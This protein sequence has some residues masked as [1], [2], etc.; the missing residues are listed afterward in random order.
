MGLLAVEVWLGLSCYWCSHI[1]LMMFTWIQLCIL[2][3]KWVCAVSESWTMPMHST[4]YSVVEKVALVMESFQR[5]CIEYGFS[6]F[7]LKNYNIKVSSNSSCVL[8]WTVSR[9]PTITCGPWWNVRVLIHALTCLDVLHVYDET[10]RTSGNKWP[11]AGDN[12][13]HW[14]WTSSTEIQSN[15]MNYSMCKSQTAVSFTTTAVSQNIAR[16]CTVKTCYIISLTCAL[17][18]HSHAHVYMCVCSLFIAVIGLFQMPFLFLI[19]KRRS[20]CSS[21]GLHSADILLIWASQEGDLPK[22]EVRAAL[23]VHVSCLLR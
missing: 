8:G 12:Q 5:D 18:R 11:C 20:V 2:E 4:N 14:D 3:T 9:G 7:T 10:H 21:A 1:I 23:Y 17:E 15:R 13:T 16:T 19:L 22:L 6:I